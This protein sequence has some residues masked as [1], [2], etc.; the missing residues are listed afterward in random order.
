MVNRLLQ[1]IEAC[2]RASI[3]MTGEL[4][5]EECTKILELAIDTAPNRHALMLE[6]AVFIGSALEGQVLLPLR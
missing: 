3:A 6:L 2:N 1:Q 4:D 5:T